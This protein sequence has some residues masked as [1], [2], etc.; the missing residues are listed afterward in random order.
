MKR[1]QWAIKNDAEWRFD[2]VPANQLRS[3]CI[4]EFGRECELLRSKVG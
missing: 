4:W 2:E 3:A 1:R